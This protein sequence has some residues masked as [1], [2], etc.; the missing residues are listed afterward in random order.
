MSYFSSLLSREAHTLRLPKSLRSDVNRYV[1]Q[2]Q[3]NAVSYERTPF[4]RRLDL[5]AYGVATAV[6]ESLEPLSVEETRRNGYK[7]A[8]TVSV[9]LSS[10][11]C[12]L[13]AVVAAARLGPRHEGVTQ[14]REIVEFGNRLAASGCPVVVGKLRDADLRLTP[15]A[16]VQAHAESLFAKAKGSRESE[17]LSSNYDLASAIRAE[18]D[19][20]EFKSTLRTNLHTKI[21]DREIETA[22][23]KTVAGFLNTRGGILII[24]VDDSGEPIGI[25]ADRFSDEDSMNL[26]FVNIVRDR[27]EASTLASMS[28]S[29]EDFKGERVLVVRCMRSPAPVFVADPGKSRTERFY[30]RTG[31]AT[32]ELRAS[33]T[34]S[35]IEKWFK[36]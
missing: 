19:T 7:F 18:S 16:K 29:F 32:T 8:D 6:A 28:L 12:G 20:L 1:R 14:A 13:L 33:Q 35:Y 34:Q 5:W 11:L 23:L 31:A 2:H 36:T 4:R 24:G 9:E 30:I 21:R 3:P 22:V 26:H 25:G 10:D 15:L 17:R 27:M